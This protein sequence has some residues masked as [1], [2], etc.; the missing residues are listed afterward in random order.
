M[1]K[2][3]KEVSVS[4]MQSWQGSAHTRITHSVLAAFGTCKLAR[5][6][7]GAARACE[8]KAG[9]CSVRGGRMEC[10]GGA[11]GGKTELPG[12]K[13]QHDRQRAGAIPS[14]PTP[15]LTPQL[16]HFRLPGGR[17]GGGGGLGGLGG[18]GRGGEGGKLQGGHFAGG[19]GDALGHCRRQ[20]QNGRRTQH[21]RAQAPAATLEIKRQG[22]ETWPILARGAA[23]ADTA[24][25][26]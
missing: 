5:R 18:G 9:G 24:L 10:A 7:G 26:A 19:A 20:R 23:L 25:L 11:A 12:L 6:R 2:H 8:L 22:V 15:P 16:L 17:G 21:T 4:S 13:S 1:S 14:T 3:K